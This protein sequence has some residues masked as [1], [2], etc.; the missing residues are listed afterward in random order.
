MKFMPTFTFKVKKIFN[1]TIQTIKKQVITKKKQKDEQ[2][3]LYLKVL[4]NQKAQVV[5]VIKE[6]FRIEE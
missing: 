4:N 5:Q 1:R 3:A 2:K 6:I